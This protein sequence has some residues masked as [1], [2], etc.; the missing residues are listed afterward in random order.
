MSTT[1]G[2]FISIEGGER[3]GKTTQA[4]MLAAWLEERGGEVVLT[5]EP[6]GT[7]AGE[8]IRNLLLD[9]A[10]SNIGPVTEALLFA[11]SRGQLVA[12]VIRPALEA[13]KFVVADRYVDSSLAYQVFGLGLPFERVLAVNEWATGGLWPD[14]TF[15]LDGG[16]PSRFLGRAREGPADRIE[17]RQPAFHEKVARGYRRLAERFPRRVVLVDGSRPP[18]EV[19]S[20]IRSIVSSRL[21]GREVPGQ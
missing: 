2:F 4:G 3:A 9:P 16:D 5:R 8:V 11:A 18:G 7:P 20:E 10:G 21:A 12:D 17:R 19:A 14:V 13:G 1:R 6:G 15:V